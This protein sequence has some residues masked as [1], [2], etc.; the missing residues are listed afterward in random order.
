MSQRVQG[1]GFLPGNK[2]ER[3]RLGFHMMPPGGIGSLNDPNGC[4]QFKGVYHLFHQYQPRFPEVY[5]R[6]WGHAWSYDLAY[7]HHTGLS[8]HED[9]PFDAHGAFSGCALAEDTGQTLRLFY[10]GNFKEP[11]DHNFVYEGRLA[12]QITTTTRDGVHFSAKRALLLPQDY[13]EYASCHVRDPKVWAQDDGGP[14]R[15]HMLLGARDKQDSGFIMIYDS[16]DKLH[17]TW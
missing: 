11:G 15:F 16:E 7:W 6:A 5:P 4:C 12:S 14:N 17:W 8:I 3:W 2:Q 10:T 9:S 13:P 1:L